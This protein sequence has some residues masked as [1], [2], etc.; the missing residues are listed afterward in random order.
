MEEKERPCLYDRVPLLCSRSWHRTV[1]QLYVHLKHSFLETTKNSFIETTQ[2]N[3]FTETT[4]F[5]HGNNYS[6][7]ETTTINKILSLK[8]QQNSFIETATVLEK[9]RVPGLKQK[10]K[11]WT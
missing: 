5:L 11:G 1:N 9:G 10:Q 3:S 7:I 2:Q 8:Q 4:K 6:F